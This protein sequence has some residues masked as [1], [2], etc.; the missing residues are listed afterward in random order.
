MIVASMIIGTWA[1]CAKRKVEHYY[2]VHR[3]KYEVAANRNNPYSGGSRKFIRKRGA[4]N[5]KD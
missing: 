1:E 5:S 2:E 3:E 4:V